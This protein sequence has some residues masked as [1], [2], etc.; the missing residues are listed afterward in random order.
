MSASF[1]FTNCPIL[2]CCAD[3]LFCG[4][5]SA[6]FW[7]T[8]TSIRY[9]QFYDVVNHYQHVFLFKKDDNLKFS[10]LINGQVLRLSQ[11]HSCCLF[12]GI[13]CCKILPLSDTRLGC[14]AF[15]LFQMVWWLFSHHLHIANLFIVLSNQLGL[16]EPTSLLQNM[17][18]HRFFS[19]RLLRHGISVIA[20]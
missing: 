7:W 19:H 13:Q 8:S 17:F 3:L 12:C 10:S 18:G 11:F 16:A 14:Q 6:K 2:L 9:R 4:C 20:K 5:T 1:D 15:F